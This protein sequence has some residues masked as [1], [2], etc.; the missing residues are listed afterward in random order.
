[1][2]ATDAAVLQEFFRLL[3]LAIVER[4]QALWWF[5]SNG[6]RGA[7]FADYQKST[8]GLI[9]QIEAL[10]VPESL[11]AMH[12]DVIDAL[13]DQRAYFEEWQRVVRRSESF[14][15]PPGA[16][17]PHPRVLSSSQKLQQAYG[18]LIQLYP[19]ETER[20]KQAFFDHLCALDFI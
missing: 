20:T 11:K 3:N 19:H 10:A 7:A 8:D 2:S 15:Y 13:K 14:K 16:S 12:R 1:M 4:V 18:R 17:P 9:R 5:Q 6:K